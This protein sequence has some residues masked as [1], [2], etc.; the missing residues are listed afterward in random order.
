MLNRF[1]VARIHQTNVA[2]RAVCSERYFPL[3]L[4]YIGLL[5]PSAVDC[6]RCN[7]DGRA[8]PRGGVNKMDVDHRGGEGERYDGGEQLH[9]LEPTV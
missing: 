4:A 3:C 2:G 5:G 6:P 9:L 7:L 8:V 1:G